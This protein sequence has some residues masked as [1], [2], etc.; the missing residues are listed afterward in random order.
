MDGGKAPANPAQ[1]SRRFGFFSIHRED[2]ARIID[3]CDGSPLAALAVW[4]ALEDLANEHQATTF[5]ASIGIIRTRAGVSRASLF[6]ALA[7][8]EGF[9][10]VKHQ[11]NHNPN[12]SKS[13]F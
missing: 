6:S 9:G 5:D 8:L 10:M 1:I 2:C 12:K 3:N 7:K 4:M 11:R 13:V